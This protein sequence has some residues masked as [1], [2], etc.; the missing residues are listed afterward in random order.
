MGVLADSHPT[1]NTSLP[2]MGSI[3]RATRALQRGARL[4]ATLATKLLP[5]MRKMERHTRAGAVPNREI[6]I[7]ELFRIFL[8]PVP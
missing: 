6:E 4:H 2:V 3:R 8:K 5:Y 7:L 1:S